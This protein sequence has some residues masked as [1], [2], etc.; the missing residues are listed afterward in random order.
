MQHRV[1]VIA[2]RLS[3]ALLLCSAAFS[4][5]ITA[6][7]QGQVSDNTGA[8][9]TK[10]AITA[11]NTETGLSRSATSDDTGEY[12]IASLPVGNYKVEAKAGTFQPQS[13]RAARGR[14]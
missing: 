3:L 5:T 12:K 14:A 9:L 7:L 11:T 6:S 4:Q 8:V 13:L 10:A 2:V 1:V